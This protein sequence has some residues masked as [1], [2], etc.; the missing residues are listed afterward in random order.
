MGAEVRYRGPKSGGADGK[1]ARWE[2][3]REIV[4][5]LR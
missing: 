4:V 1:T 5:Y 2:E 3:M